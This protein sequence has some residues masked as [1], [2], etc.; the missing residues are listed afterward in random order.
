MSKGEALINMIS[1]GDRQAFDSLCRERYI[2]L[3]SYARL[4]LDKTAAEDVV[5]D[6]LMSV[7]QGRAGLKKNGSLEAYLIKSVYNRSMNILNHGKTVQ[8]YR[9]W[10]RQRI[11][12]LLSNYLSP[13]NN[14][15]MLKIYNRELNMKLNKAISAL[16]ERCRE[17]FVMRYL[18]NMSEKE[19]SARL[20]ISVSTVENHIYTAL[21]RLRAS[22]SSSE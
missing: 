9:S 14:P 16:P 20:G 15:V 6:V 7:W 21:Q 10:Y 3:L 11:D 22:L 8:N 19:I 17:V 5:Q 18:E 13:E 2:P 12:S 4:F 1:K